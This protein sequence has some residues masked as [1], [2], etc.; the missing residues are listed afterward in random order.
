[1]S[2]LPILYHAACWRCTTPYD[3]VADEIGVSFEEKVGGTIRLRLSRQ[4]ATHLME[5]LRECLDHPC[6]SHSERSSGMPSLDG[7]TP[8]EGDQV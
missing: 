3:P 1:M 8:E 5:T 7:S 6:D 4:C 2:H